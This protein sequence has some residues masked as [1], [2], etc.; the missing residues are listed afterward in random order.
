MHY[1]ELV[2]LV[3]TLVQGAC[4]GTICTIGA[5]GVP[6]LGCVDQR[7][8]VFEEEQAELGIVHSELELG[9]RVCALKRSK[10]LVLSSEFTKSS[11]SILG[12]KL[13][14]WGMS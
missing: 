4:L 12:S 2:T 14:F 1:Y 7:L 6:G 9:H 13:A 10:M 8:H 11:G 5:A 3:M